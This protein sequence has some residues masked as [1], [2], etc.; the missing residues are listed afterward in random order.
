MSLAAVLAGCATTD[1]TQRFERA[2]A[3][4][5][6]IAGEVAGTTFRHRTFT[7]PSPDGHRGT[8]LVYL[9]GDGTPFLGRSR[10][11]SDPTPRRPLTLE[12]MARGP[13]PAVYLGRPCYHG[14]R[15]GCDPALWTVARYSEAV[16]A[17]LTEAL[18]RLAAQHRAERVVLVGYSGGGALALLVAERQPTVDA[19]I[20]LAANLDTDAWT[21]L[22]G[23]SP[24]VGSLNPADAAGNRRVL[25]HLHLTGD[26]DA[27]VPPFLHDRLRDRL[28]AEAFVT[29]PGFDHRCCWTKAWPSL[30]GVDRLIEPAPPARV[31]AP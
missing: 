26:A 28:P 10:I 16:V 11:A 27:N 4:A 25:R 13:R 1:P 14:L 30:A 9:G 15:A 21:A 17:S 23:Y 2:A 5:G 3:R 12:L 22:H 6:F 19:V 31:A 7:A 29:V 8:L 20:T 24:L 18:T